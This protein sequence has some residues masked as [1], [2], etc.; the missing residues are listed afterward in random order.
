MPFASRA[1]TVIA[2]GSGRRRVTTTSS[3]LSLPDQARTRGAISAAVIAHLIRDRRRRHRIFTPDARLDDNCTVCSTDASNELVDRNEADNRKLSTDRRSRLHATTRCS[4]RRSGE[5][6]A[7]EPS[8][9][10]D[11]ESERTDRW[12]GHDH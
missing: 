9:A 7:P 11:P 5:T 12:H 10:K 1:G 4:S 2:E 6:A 3:K 8:G